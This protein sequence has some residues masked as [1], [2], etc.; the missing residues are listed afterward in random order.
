MDNAQ[1]ARAQAVIAAGEM[2]K[3]TGATLWDAPEW[4]M[5]VTDDVGATVCGLRIQG[6]T[7]QD[8]MGQGGGNRHLGTDLR[9]AREGAP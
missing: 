3:D 4:R 2:L 8:W 6:V 1:Q 9:R 5:E 7:K